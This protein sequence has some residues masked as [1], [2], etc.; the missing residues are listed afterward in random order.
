ML[1]QVAIV[2]KLTQKQTE[3]GVEEKVIVDPMFIIAPNDQAAAL[4]TVVANKDKIG[5]RAD[6]T[7]LVRNF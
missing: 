3:E 5:D 6:I 1:Y 2:E 7:V 4:R